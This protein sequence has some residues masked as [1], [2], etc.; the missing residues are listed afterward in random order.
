MILPRIQ[1]PT[2]AE[3]SKAEGQNKAEK[4]KRRGSRAVNCGEGAVSLS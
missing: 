2:D 3:E 1:G 4:V